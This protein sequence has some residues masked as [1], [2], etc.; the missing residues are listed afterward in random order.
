M[1]ATAVAILHSYSDI[2]IDLKVAKEE[3]KALKN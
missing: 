3:V 2:M 1:G